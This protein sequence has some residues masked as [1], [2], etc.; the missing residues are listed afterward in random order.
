[1]A[2]P[3]RI[4]FP[5][6]MYHVIVRGNERKAVFRDDADREFYL[7]RVAHY[8][9]KCGFRL[10]AYC[11]MSNHVHLAI[12]TVREPLSRIMAGLQSSYTQ[13]FNRRHGRVGHLFQGRY[14]AFLVEKDRYALALL[15]YLHEN[16]V[17]A[18]IVATPEE[19]VW[20]S[21]RHYRKGRGPDWLDADRLLE[22]LGAPRSA[23]TRAYRRLMREEAAAPYE[24]VTSWGQAVK[25]DQ[26]FADLAFQKIGEPKL[27]RKG[28]TVEAVARE[29]ARRRKLSVEKMRSPSQGRPE[30]LGRALVAWAGRE[31]GGL[32][33]AR[34]AKYFK[35]DTSSMARVVQR[36]VERTETSRELRRFSEQL[37]SALHSQ[38]AI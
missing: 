3:I 11:L 33:I 18:R 35:R 25:G 13:Y 32:S 31:A 9:E 14:K 2:R 24:E 37:V 21:D 8:R 19:Y 5:G 6:A 1:M 15:R 29:V 23:A 27:L 20:S 26:P 30:A 22:M 16:P 12:E 4:E 36:L 7:R 28:L 17:K 10:L 34:A 38:H